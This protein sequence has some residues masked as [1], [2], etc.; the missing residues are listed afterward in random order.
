MT[1]ADRAR[2]L[3]AA[4][5]HA[6]LLEGQ[7]RDLTTVPGDTGALAAALLAVHALVGYTLLEQHGWTS[8]AERYRVILRDLSRDLCHDH[9]VAGTHP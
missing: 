2:R 6:A 1:T 8:A 4:N 9:P 3:E 5:A 7:L